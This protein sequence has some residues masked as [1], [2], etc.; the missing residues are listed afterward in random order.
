MAPA[1]GRFRR[2]AYQVRNYVEPIINRL[3]RLSGIATRH[4]KGAANYLAM[5]TIGMAP[6]AK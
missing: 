1:H 5:V 4:E 2:H 3:A 6:P